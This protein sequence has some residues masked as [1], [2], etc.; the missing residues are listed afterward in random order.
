MP[1]NPFPLLNIGQ[2]DIAR[3]QQQYMP[4]FTPIPGAMPSMGGYAPQ[5]E[6][7]ADA[8]GMQALLRQYGQ[9]MD[10]S[11]DLKAAR[12]ERKSA[13]EEF[14]KTLDTLMKGGDEGPSQAELYFKL[15]AALGRP[16]RFGSFAESLGP[17][18]EAM[19]EYQGD[20]RKAGQAKKKLAT[21]IALKKQEMALESAKD[22]EKTLLGLQSEAN[23][24]KREIIKAQVQEYIQSGKPQSEAGRIAKDKGFKVGTP[25][26]Q[27][28]VDKQAKM[29]IEKQLASISATLAGIQVQ[30][31]Q[32]AL[33]TKKE[34]RA[35]SELDPTE[36]KMLADNK[37]SLR[38]TESAVTL[39]DEALTYID[40]AFTKSTA[41]QAQYRRLKVSN[42]D[43]P[44]VVA[45]EQLEQILTTSGLAG[46]RA[47][48][49]GNPTE[50]ER[51][52]QLLT[53]GLGATSPTSRRSIINRVKAN[54]EK[55]KD[56]FKQANEDLLSG[57]YKKKPSSKE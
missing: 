43:D 53:Q 33:A 55:N 20:V 9:T 57:A 32:L 1:A 4:D 6:P 41:D 42:P 37:Q 52:V 3:L 2:E 35:A 23:K 45:T 51:Q 25:E 11:E 34:E 40:K 12:Q 16:T 29:L 56:F 54:L 36:L 48:F 21:E 31:G 17:A 15:A 44:R 19:A 28:E 7:A 14:N 50:G 27:E 49:G 30:Q 26:Y 22:T 39:M 38:N 8:S 10:Y 46:L 13:Q 24:D 18:A 47:S 5:P